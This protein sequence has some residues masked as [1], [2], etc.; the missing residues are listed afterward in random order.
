MREARGGA[1]RSRVRKSLLDLDFRAD[2][3][4]LLLDRV[5]LVLRDPFLDRLGRAFDEVL[6]F[7]QAE[8]GD[9]AHDL[10]DVDLVGAD[11][12]QR[13][14][15]LGLLLGR[16]RRAAAGRTRR[17]A[18]EHGHRRRC[19]HA[20]LGLER[21]DEL[22]ELENGDAFDVVD[23][24]LLRHFGHWCLSFLL[25]VRG[26]PPPRTRHRSLTLAALI[27]NAYL[28][29]PQRWS[30]GPSACHGSPLGSPVSH[31]TI[32]SVNG[33]ATVQ[34][35]PPSDFFFSYCA[36]TLTKSRGTPLSTRTRLAIGACSVPSSCAYSSGLPGIVA[37]SV[38]CAGSM[39]LPWTTAALI[40]SVG[41][42]LTNVV[43]VFA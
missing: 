38:T 8:R 42:V 9:L 15:E 35:C 5:G 23:H 2:V 19:R 10:D 24:L 31:S 22:R 36:S 41:A 13:D 21:L 17:A 37:R 11:F 32:R 6:G 3:L 14:G 7:L 30:T 16:S 34:P 26:A 43:S 27:S 28:L 25:F 4:E 33:V 29:S 40:F 12:R 18:G 20:E 39:A 1:P